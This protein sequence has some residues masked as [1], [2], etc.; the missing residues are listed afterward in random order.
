MVGKITILGLVRVA[1]PR[2]NVHGEAASAQMVERC[3]LARSKGRGDKT[4]SMRQQQSQT[5][6]D[7]RGMRA[8]EEA[9]WRIGKV[10]YQDAIEIRLLVGVGRRR[11]DFSIEWRSAGCQHLRRYARRDPANNLDRQSGLQVIP[12]HS[13][14]AS[15]ALG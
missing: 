2:D 7:G 14:D 1:T 6:G 5:L 11:D 3:K 9:I 8:D 13:R 4:R 15:R 12:A 10:A